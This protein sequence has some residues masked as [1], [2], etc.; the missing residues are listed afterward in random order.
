MFGLGKPKKPVIKK[1]LVPQKAPDPKKKPAPARHSSLSTP[2]QAL[3][4]DATRAPAPK[5]RPTT[6][7]HT[8]SVKSRAKTD[9]VERKAKSLKR[10]RPGTPQQALSSDSEG[11]DD[12]G[13]AGATQRPLKTP[14]KDALGPD[15]ARTIWTTDAPMSAEDLE[16]LVHAADLTSGKHFATTG[17]G[18]DLYNPA[19]GVEEG[20]EIVTVELQYPSAAPPERYVDSCALWT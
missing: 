17:V 1:V 3:A 8:N 7:G 11:D 14:K 5:S 2:A 18:P 9:G 15:T 13:A 19:F 20:E 10:K 6:N 4:R 16:G 12:F